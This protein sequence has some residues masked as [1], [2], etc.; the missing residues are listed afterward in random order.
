MR[1]VINVKDLRGLAL[2]SEVVI[3]LVTEAGKQNHINRGLS[4]C[5]FGCDGERRCLCACRNLINGA[6]VLT[7]GVC[8]NPVQ[9]GRAGKQQRHDQNC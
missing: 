1:S 4:L 3:G 5:L 7:G 6:F 8:R 2:V 9:A